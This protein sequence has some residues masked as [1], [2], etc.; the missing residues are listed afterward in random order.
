MYEVIAFI[1]ASAFI[2]LTSYNIGYNRGKD[3]KETP[4]KKE[5]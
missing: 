2:A 1:A 4:Q 3:S 5:E